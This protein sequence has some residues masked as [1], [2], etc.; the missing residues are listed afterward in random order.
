MLSLLPAILGCLSLVAAQ[1]PGEVNPEVHPK[2]QWTK[3]TTNETCQKVQGE[4]VLNDNFRW[5]HQ[6]NTYRNCYDGGRWNSWVCDS[7]TNCT[8]TC[9]IEGY[10]VF[11]LNLGLGIK[12][13]DDSITLKYRTAENFMVNIGSRVHLLESKEKYQMFTLLNNEF[14]FDVNLSTVG[15]GINAA[16]HFVAMDEDGGK[17]RFSGNKAGAEYGTGYCNSQCTRGQRFVGGKANMEGWKQ[18]ETDRENGEGSLG[19][20]CPEFAVWYVILIVFRLS[21]TTTTDAGTQTPIRSSS[22][23]TSVQ[24]PRTSTGYVRQT[25]APTRHTRRSREEESVTDGDAVITRTRW[26]PRTFTGRVR[27]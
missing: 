2:L 8:E 22:H 3:C 13:I 9:V 11:G 15:C 7:N 14:A 20:C 19:A 17:A 21:L 1:K 25:A 16:L 24:K 12:A 5:I 26:E 4:V 10:D 6:A 23:P 27:R 18:S